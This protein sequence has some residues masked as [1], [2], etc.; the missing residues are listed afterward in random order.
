MMRAKTAR[1]IPIA[2][3]IFVRPAVNYSFDPG[4]MEGGVDGVVDG[5]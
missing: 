5:D 4:V 1:G 3:P 2:I